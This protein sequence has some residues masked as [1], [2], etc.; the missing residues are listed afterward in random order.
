MNIICNNCV[1]ARLYEVQ[2][3]QFVNPFTWCEIPIDDFIRL[4]ENFDSIKLI[5][6]AIFSIEKY[7]RY[8]YESVNVTL[9]FNIQCHFV[10]YIKDKTYSYPGKD[11]SNT[12]IRYNDI[13]AYAKETWIK[14][15]LRISETPI[16]MYSFNYL[17]PNSEQYNETLEK[18]INININKEIWI[19][20]HKSLN[21][22]CDKNNIKI[23]NLPDNVFEF[24]GTILANKLSEYIILK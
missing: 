23:F 4:I 6:D 18:L 11:E 22:K 20:T 2:H 16:F 12:N 5:T 9:P 13:L 24:N 14:R 3:K 15:S 10:H 1:G 21:I 19:L 8:D 7:G 17:Q